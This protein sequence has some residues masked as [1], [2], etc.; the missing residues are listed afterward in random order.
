MTTSQPAL[1]HS[2]VHLGIFLLLLFS[3][4]VLS[5][6]DSSEPTPTFTLEVTVEPNEGGSATPSSGEFEQGETVDI[7]ADPADGFRL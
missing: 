5:G 3:G 6:C 1:R 2:A 4:F 7:T